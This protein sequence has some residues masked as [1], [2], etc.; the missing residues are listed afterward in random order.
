MGGRL[1]SIVLLAVL[2]AAFVVAACGHDGAGG[3][4]RS[5]RGAII[6]ARATSLTELA[7]F[8]LHTNDGRT[9]EFTPAPDASRDPKVGLLPGHLRTHAVLGDQVEV[10]YR[11]EG[12]KL[13]A[14]RIEDRPRSV[15]RA[16]S[17]SRP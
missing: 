17:R 4:E 2:V 14:L 13:L 11:E 5:V 8:T 10:Y 3:N 15:R 9:L 16:P 1:G 6:D 7:S 12:G